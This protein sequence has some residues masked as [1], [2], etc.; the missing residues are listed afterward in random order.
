MM[1]SRIALCEILPTRNA[2]LAAR[3]VT[4][5]FKLRYTLL[6]IRNLSHG[7]GNIYNGFSRQP[8]KGGAPHMLDCDYLRTYG[9]TQLRFFFGKQL[10]P[11]FRMG[12]QS[13]CPSL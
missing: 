8:A 12:H 9:I 2:K 3:F 5:V 6:G 7:N 10:M 1:G 4:D 13:Y 11:Q